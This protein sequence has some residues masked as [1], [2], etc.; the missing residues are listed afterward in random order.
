KAANRRRREHG[1]H[2]AMV[3]SA[4]QGEPEPTQGTVHSVHSVPRGTHRASEPPSGRSGG[5]GGRRKEERLRAMHSPH[6]S[7]P[8]ETTSQSGSERRDDSSLDGCTKKS[9]QIV[10]AM[11]ERFESVSRRRCFSL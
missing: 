11:K 7:R 2:L 1:C 10:L 4:H 9:T 5:D 8:C 6:H 3:D